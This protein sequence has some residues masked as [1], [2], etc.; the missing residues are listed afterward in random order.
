MKVNFLHA[1][2]PITKTYTKTRNGITKTPY[3]FVYEVS[4]LEYKTDSLEDLFTCINHHAELG[5]CLL[6]GELSREL[7]EESRAG[8]TD[9]KQKT[10]WICLDLDGVRGYDTVDTFLH[11][12]GCGGTDYILQWS[13]SQGVDGTTDIRCHIFMLLETAM[14]PEQ[15]KRWLTT[16]NL[17]IPNLREQLQLTR[18]N[19][20]LRWG[21]DITT[22][23][24]DKLLYI[25]PPVFEK[26]NDPLG[27]GSR[28]S[29]VKGKKRKLAITTKILEP[30]A[31]RHLSDKR[32]NELREAE[33][34]PKRNA[35][36]KMA[37]TVE[38]VQGPDA[39]NVTDIRQERGF[40][41]LNLNGGDS[42]AYYHPENNPT[43]IYNFKGEPPYKTEE[44]LP[45]YWAEVTARMKG[46]DK[47]LTGTVYLAFRDFRTS[48]YYNGIYDGA[49]KRLTM[50]M[51]K[52]ESQLKSFLK[53]HG[54]IVGDYIPDWDLIFDPHSEDVIDVENRTVNTF[55]PSAIMENV[56]PPL[57]T[58]V[59]PTCHKIISHVLGNDQEC[60]DHFMNWLACVIQFLDRTGTAWVLQGKQGTG[61]GLLYHSI[62]APILGEHNVVAKRMEELESE[63]TGF[64]ENKFITAIDEIE[65]GS[66]MYHSK[67]T[68]KLKNLIV[69]PFISI[70]KMYTP[71]YMSRN[72]NSMIFSSNKPDS[73]HISPDDRRFNVAPYQNEKLEITAREVDDLLPLELPN[74]YA[75]LMHYEADRAIARTPL[76]NA[77]RV[78]LI[79]ISTAAVDVVSNALIEGDFDFLWDQLPSQKPADTGPITNPN[80]FKYERY[81]ATLL[82]L[83]AEREDGTMTRDDLYTIYDYCD[84]NTPASP[85]KFTALLKHHKIYLKPI[86]AHGKTVR[87]ILVKWNLSEQRISE[88]GKEIENN[89]V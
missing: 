75:F 30:A 14:A 19:C 53:Q 56:K 43:F 50:A 63:F 22:C 45:Q 13:S 59:P 42:W 11:S 60:Y 85:N 27:D 82:K 4:S 89:T 5:D 8:C 15:L 86:W 69:E 36:Y 3:P 81:R 57:V 67:I 73:V 23:Q 74:F 38:Y 83:F 20:S 16:L 70:R 51:A 6:K 65:V 24:N 49:N 84:G 33:S 9:S 61:K 2:K 40:V 44:L 64:I 78:S 68:A 28:I 29:I 76:N 1:H 10:E 47:D 37:G 25:A 41:Y 31:L 55:R 58:V 71:A 88:I 54:Q 17:T 79:D 34:M 77:A 72:Y 7:V 80:H 52:N 32:V 66:S 48:N 35:K 87:G 26:M 18:T 21:L 12:I 46:A 39:A 62:I